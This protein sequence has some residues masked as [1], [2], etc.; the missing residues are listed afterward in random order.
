MTE[1]VEFWTWA[2]G[3]GAAKRAA[4]AEEQG[5]DGIGVG[6]SQSLQLDSYVALALAASATSRLKLATAV[7]NPLTR[8]PAVTASAIA[9]V[10]AE[11]NGRAVL[12]IGRGDSA[13]AHLGLA[14]AP[15]QVF[16]RYL[17]RV[18]EFLRGEDVPFDRHED[19][20]QEVRSL[21][22]FEISGRPTTSRL[23]WLDQELAKVPVDVA[24][25]GPRM[26]ALAAAHAEQITFAVGADVARLAWAIASAET[27]MRE[28]ARAPGAVTFGAYIPVLVHPDRDAARD[29][30][31]G[32]AASVARFSVMHGKTAG[33]LNA[34]DDAALHT[35]HQSYS[36]E[37]H[38][39]LGA[40][41]ASTMTGDLVDRW[42]VAGP[43]DY[44]I[45]R[46]NE[47]VGAGLQ[48]IFVLDA[49]FGVERNISRQS[50][51]LFCGEVMPNV[52][53]TASSR[54]ERG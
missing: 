3:R 49:G 54:S 30:V 24:A 11:S 38:F 19:G 33:P 2:N 4:R 26:I 9:S 13:L 8:L 10:N 47:L 7:T 28:A 16:A 53:A 51:Q 43:P 21:E 48:K 41:H 45:G 40:D 39:T 50:R 32:M 27:A 29:L 17:Q 14:P 12:G 6:D 25:S 34:A 52:R 18:Q 23:R 44:C 37:S 31:S 22:E 1:T 5:W 46:L 35:I 20:R 42:S 15:V 36:M